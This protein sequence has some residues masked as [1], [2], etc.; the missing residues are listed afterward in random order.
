MQINTNLIALNI[1]I[2]VGSL[3]FIFFNVVGGFPPG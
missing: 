2:P 1:K 3:A